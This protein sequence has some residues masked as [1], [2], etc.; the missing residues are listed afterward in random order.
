[1]ENN[2]RSKLNEKGEIDREK[3]F[4]LGSGFGG[5][6]SV[7]W[8]WACMCWRVCSVAYSLGVMIVD[9]YT[10]TCDA[11]AIPTLIEME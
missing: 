7:W 9:H 10:T 11:L 2:V 8:C 5:G 3:E 1:M 4:G 6:V